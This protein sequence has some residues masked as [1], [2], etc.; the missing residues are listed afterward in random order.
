MKGVR[1]NVVKCDN[2]G[3]CFMPIDDQEKCPFC[4]HLLRSVN[5]SDLLSEGFANIFGL[6]DRK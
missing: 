1:M 2:C 6:K 3:K 5:N 4:K